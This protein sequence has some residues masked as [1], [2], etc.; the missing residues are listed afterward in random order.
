MSDCP[1]VLTP[2]QIERIHAAGSEWRA[3]GKTRESAAR[4]ERAIQ[5]IENEVGHRG[6]AFT[7]ETRT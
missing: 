2:D 6:P 7:V 3:A 5:T 4:Y 1:P